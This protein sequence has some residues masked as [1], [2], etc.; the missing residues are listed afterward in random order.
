MFKKTVLA[1][2][3]ITAMSVTAIASAEESPKYDHDLYGVI[4][5]QLA[6]RDYNT[7]V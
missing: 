7:A 2:S 3:I 6:H 1:A 4:A 5:V